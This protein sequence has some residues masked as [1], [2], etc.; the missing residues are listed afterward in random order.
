[1]VYYGIGKGDS[2]VEHTRTFKSIY[3]NLLTVVSIS[4]VTVLISE[5]LRIWYLDRQII[6]MVYILAVLLISR[7]TDGYGWG[8]FAAI[9]LSLVFDYLNTYPR[10]GF[11]LAELPLTLL[12]MLIVTLIA[13][14]MTAQSRKQA[15]TAIEQAEDSALLYEISQSLLAARDVETIIQTTNHFLWERTGRAVVFYTRD[16]LD[17]KAEPF[18]SSAVDGGTKKQLLAKSERMRAHQFYTHPGTEV[19]D[20]L[21]AGCAH[22]EPVFSRG[23]LFGLIGVYSGKGQFSEEWILFIRAVAAQVALVLESLALASEQNQILLEAEREKTR[24]SLLRAISHDLRTPLT[25]ILGASTTMLEQEETL[26]KE[27][28]TMLLG[29]IRETAQWLIHTAENLLTITKLSGETIILKKTM[30]AA[31]EVVAGSVA[32]VRRRFPSCHIHLRSP[33]SLLL[34][35]ME[36]TLIS[37]VLINLIE[38]SIKNGD[39]ESLIL[40]DVSAHEDFAEFS[41][42][43]TGRGIP[44]EMLDSL[45]ELR[46]TRDIHAVD[47]VQGMGIGLSICKTIIHAHG[48]AITGKNKADGGAH[49]SFTLP[50]KEGNHDGT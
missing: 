32:I 5:L 14:A 50:T 4:L 46:G 23:N 17:Q 49:F 41:V 28:S 6:A 18:L 30:E 13:S 43:D 38:N 11:G 47:S 25:S 40:V 33:K 20:Y 45:F 15:E 3:R 37:Q 22:Y 8:I 19:S 36:A 48:G 29:D 10:M 27:T 35:P 16:P 1:M 42:S 34:V 9:S 12:V 7:F 39:M 26:D 21:A 2:P 24:A 31:E 44:E